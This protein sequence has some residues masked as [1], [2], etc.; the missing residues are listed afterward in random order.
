MLDAV[1]SPFTPILVE[2]IDGMK[3]VVVPLLDSVT[4]LSGWLSADAPKFVVP[5]EYS[6]RALR[7]DAWRTSTSSFVK[8]WRSLWT[9]P[10]VRIVRDILNTYECEVMVASSKCTLCLCCSVLFTGPAFVR[11]M[12][13]KRSSRLVDPRYSL[14]CPPRCVII[15]RDACILV[16]QSD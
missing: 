14:Q 2:L 5:V 8:F 1:W 13:S 6:W 3:S 16:M 12:A 7:N 4:V 10:S 11:L 9:S 15:T